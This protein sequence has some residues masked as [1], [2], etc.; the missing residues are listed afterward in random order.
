MERKP[1]ILTEDGRKRLQ[2][3]LEHLRTVR[4]PGIAERIQQSKE[5][6]S[7]SNNAEWDDAKNDQAFV[8]GKILELESMLRTASVAQPLH[9]GVVGIGSVVTLKTPDGDSETYTIVGSLEASAI[10]GRISNESPVGQALLGKKVGQEIEV[11]VPA[12]KQRLKIV[13]VQ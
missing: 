1:V 2:D 6:Q 4:R 8:E 10:D 5:F 7:T 9:K 13:K 12:G 11:K 3:E